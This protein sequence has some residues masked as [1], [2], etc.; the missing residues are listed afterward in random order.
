MPDNFTEWG[1]WFFL[2]LVPLWLLWQFAR[3][4]AGG[5]RALCKPAVSRGFKAFGI[6]LLLLGCLVVAAGAVVAPNWSRGGMH[7]TL[8]GGGWVL[9]SVWLLSTAE[10]QFEKSLKMV[11]LSLFALGS[12]TNLAGVAWALAWPSPRWLGDASTPD[13]LSLAGFALLMSGLWTLAP[14]HGGGGPG[15]GGD[16]GC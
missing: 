2:S 12:L 3:F 9:G 6:G 5:I 8:L 14:G 4:A 11:V 7:L 10:Q 1:I 16:G 13:L 15:T